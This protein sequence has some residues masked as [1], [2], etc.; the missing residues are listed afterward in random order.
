MSD[1][2]ERMS[3]ALSA[4]LRHDRPNRFDPDTWLDDRFDKY[5]PDESFV[6]LAVLQETQNVCSADQLLMPAEV[7][8]RLAGEVNLDSSGQDAINAMVDAHANAEPRSAA[9]AGVTSNQLLAEHLQDL[10]SSVVALGFPHDRSLDR[11]KG[12]KA[13]GAAPAKRGKK[14]GRE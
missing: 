7:K 1:I 10:A 8:Q 12:K 6:D 2:E 11:G 5:Y 3:D 14:R 9:R 4:R 13:S